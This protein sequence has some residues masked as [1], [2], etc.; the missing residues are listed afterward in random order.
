MKVQSKTG[1]LAIVVNEEQE[2]VG[3][4]VEGVEV[5]HPALSLGDRYRWEEEPTHEFGGHS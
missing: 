3:E 4:R 1:D 5:V 2:A